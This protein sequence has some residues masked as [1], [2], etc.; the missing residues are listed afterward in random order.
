MMKSVHK[1]IEKHKNEKWKSRK[2]VMAPAEQEDRK[3][4][5]KKTR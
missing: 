3:K 4:L 1:Y 5:I 2:R